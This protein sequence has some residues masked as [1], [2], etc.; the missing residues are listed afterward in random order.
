MSMRL[1]LDVPPSANGL[2]ATVNGRRVLSREGRQ[3]HEHVRAV[4]LRYRRRAEW[5]A[6]NLSKTI[7]YSVSLTVTLA[8]RRRRDAGGVEKAILDGLTLA[9]VW[10]DDSQVDELLIRMRRGCTEEP[11]RVDVEISHYTEQEAP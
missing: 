4:V 8:N 2:Y 1:T 7:R 6:D 5:L 11:E 10:H 3:Y 9:S